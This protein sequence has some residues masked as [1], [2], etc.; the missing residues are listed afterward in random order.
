MTKWFGSTHP[1]QETQIQVLA[2]VTSGSELKVSKDICEEFA[3]WFCLH[4]LASPQKTPPSLAVRKIWFNPSAWSYCAFPTPRGQLT[5]LSLLVLE[6][7]ECEVKLPVWTKSLAAVDVCYPTKSILV[8]HPWPLPPQPP[9]VLSMCPR[10]TFLGV[11]K[12]QLID[13]PFF[14]TRM[15]SPSTVPQT[16]LPSCLHMAHCVS[17]PIY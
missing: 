17:H 14:C 7:F 8:Q 10:Q 16:V 2:Y 11:F 1:S 3:W 4:L 5:L 12:H 13:Q 9:L 6:P 15:E